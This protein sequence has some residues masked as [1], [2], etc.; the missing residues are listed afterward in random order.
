MGKEDP[1]EKLIAAIVGGGATGAPAA[2]GGAGGAP[3]A[4]GG[5][6]AGGTGAPAPAAPGGAPAGPTGFESP[7]D[8]AALYKDLAQY[9]S[10]TQSIDRG[11]G[12]IGS[13]ISQDGNREATLNS[14]TGG[15]G[16]NI[17]VPDPGAMA[18]TAMELQKA[19]IARQQRAAMLASLPM[20]ARKYGLDLETAKMLY[21][22]GKLE[23]VIAE[24]E[25][26]NSEIV[27]AEDG[28][29]ILID[30]TSGDQRGVYGGKKDTTKVIPGPNGSNVLFDEEADQVIGSVTPR[31]MSSEYVEYTDYVNNEAKAN[32]NNPPMSFQQFRMTKPPSTQIT[33][34]MGNKLDP[35]SEAFAKKS[36]DFF[37][38]DYQK[39]RGQRSQARDMLNQYSIARKA[40]DTDVTTG[41]FGEYEQSLRKLGASMGIDTDM[42]K[43]TGGELLKTVTNRMALLMR[44]PESGMG[45]PGSVSDR[46]LTFLKDAQV[47]LTTANPKAMIDIFER[48]EKRKIEIA[49]LADKY[50]KENKKLDAGFDDVV[51]EF[52]DSNPLFEGINLKPQDPEEYRKSVYEQYRSK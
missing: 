34:N 35:E 28:T 33:N 14:F 16:S 8:F 39:F 21:E 29:N 24:R 37:A 2:G 41:T 51:R 22:Q 7:P 38:E 25:K 52:V 32:P 12:L 3:Y 9:A 13:S 31:D 48:I 11:F 44:N 1:R 5:A 26:P 17:G 50:V 30:R 42:S 6:G 47:S 45:M 4:G 19:S 49:D 15:N 27:K 23:E 10:K 18:S 43:I 40:L 36:G 46:D 20:I